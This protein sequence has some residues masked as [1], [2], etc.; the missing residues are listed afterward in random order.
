MLF[1]ERQ[2]LIFFGISAFALV[3][4]GGRAPDDAVGSSRFVQIAQ[5]DQES[6]VTKWPKIKNVTGWMMRYPPGWKDETAGEGTFE[7]SD[8]VFIQGPKECLSGAERCAWVGIRRFPRNSGY[9]KGSLKSYLHR[10]E[11][12]E[13]GPDREFL[14]EKTTALAGESGLDVYT[15][16]NVN[17]KVTVNRQIVL[18]H[19]GYLFEISYWE[20]DN[21]GKDRLEIKAPQDWKYTAIFEKMLSTFSFYKIPRPGAAAFGFKAARF[22]VSFLCP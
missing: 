20:A 15:R 9:S 3:V 22:D 12:H 7:T 19:N 14:V 21:S 8:L 17:G 10:D 11:H 5:V 16:G 4:S 1:G 18:K 13:G 6:D 2:N